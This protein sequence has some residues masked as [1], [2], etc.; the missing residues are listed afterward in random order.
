M[1]E[2][3]GLSQS[4]L[5]SPC[6]LCGGKKNKVR[7]SVDCPDNQGQLHP[8]S[9]VS[10]EG[11]GLGRTEPQPPLEKLGDFYPQDYGPHQGK[12]EAKSRPRER[13]RSGWLGGSL[14]RKVMKP[15][16]QARL[17]DFG[18]GGGSYLLRMRN[19]G[20]NV[21]GV[22][23]SRSTCDKLKKEEGLTVHYGTFPHPDLKPRSFEVV[24]MW[25]SLEHVTDPVAVLKFA[26]DLLVDGGRLI[27]AVPCW[28]SANFERYLGDWFA[29]DMPKHLF[30]FTPESLRKAIEKAGF[31]VNSVERLNHTEW[32]R[33]SAK[34][35]LSKNKSIAE[36]IRA[37]KMGARLA[38]GWI[39]RIQNRAD[40]LY[41][42]AVV[43]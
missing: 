17:L 9:M 30:H 10:C 32:L 18:C 20:W 37:T 8:F 39:H 24:T 22:D 21:V 3:P 5:E 35:R 14:E 29:L 23:A 19:Q 6:P 43:K 12:D 11:C 7:V 31:E 16:G 26:R 38:A 28:T 1:P 2:K 42:K 25:H 40:C 27:V 33:R 13:W 34:N 36:T 15:F 4:N 41:A